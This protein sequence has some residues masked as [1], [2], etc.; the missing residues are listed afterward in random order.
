MLGQP[1]SSSISAPSPQCAKTQ[2]GRPKLP[3]RFKTCRK[4]VG[5]VI[6]SRLSIYQ[7]IHLEKTCRAL[8]WHQMKLVQTLTLPHPDAPMHI[9]FDINAQQPAPGVAWS[10]T[11]LA[12]A[13][14]KQLL[15][16]CVL[17]HRPRLPL[18]LGL[19]RGR[20]HRLARLHQ[21]VELRY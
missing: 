11:Y 19:Q 5:E 7:R 18:V 3:E 2:A 15:D 4:K 9:T 8:A 10:T 21:L 1:Q 17:L 14:Q 13:I 6:E 16:L 12:E 20:D